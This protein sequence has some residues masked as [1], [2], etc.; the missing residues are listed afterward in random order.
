MIISLI[1]SGFIMENVKGSPE[2]V[3]SPKILRS[4]CEE[5]RFL[6]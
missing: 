2:G 1:M 4:F 6:V 3:F 5:S